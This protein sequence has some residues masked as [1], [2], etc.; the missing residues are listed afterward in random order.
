MNNTIHPCLWFDG[1]A[2]AAA[3]FYCSV[4]KDSSII[5]DTPMVVT[6]ELNGQRFMGLNGGPSFK[7]NASVSF[8]VVCESEAE[9]EEVWN[10][11]ADGGKALMPLDKY[12]WSEKYGW[13]Q[14]RFGL[15]WQLSFGRMEDVGQKF[16]PCL[17]FTGTQHGKA[18]QAIH[19][20]TTVFENSSVVGVLHYTEEDNDVAGT[21][22]H[23]Q[24]HLNKFVMMAMDS[25]LLHDSSF[26]EAIS[27][28]VS[29][30]TQDQIDYYWAKLTDGGEESKCGWLKDRYGVS[31][32]I[33]PSILGKL[34]TDQARSKRV[35]E[36]LMQ[37]KKLD[38]E[39]LE[40]A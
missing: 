7:F 20:Y 26:N 8:F 35:M 17:M 18:E 32:Q 27:F 33:V 5:D 22:K 21:V 39:I 23:A 11:L 14:D 15:N 36:A 12:P 24:F 13:I 29:C 31:W 3:E 16:T 10:M 4:F 40:Q 38:I 19:F 9:T 28:V 34:M 1:Q 6:F 25:S 2:K 30:D 37:M